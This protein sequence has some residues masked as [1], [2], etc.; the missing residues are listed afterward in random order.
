MDSQ[1]DNRS[2]TPPTQS[3]ARNH[4]SAALTRRSLVHAVAQ[5]VHTVFVVPVHPPLLKVPVPHAV[6]GVQARSVVAVHAPFSY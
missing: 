1:I 3:S 5:V 2:V 4:A 6:Q